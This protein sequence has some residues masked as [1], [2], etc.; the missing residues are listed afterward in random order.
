M[1]IER[2]E[3]GSRFDIATRAAWAISY[4]RPILMDFL[5]TVSL[6]DTNILKD[7]LLTML[8]CL[9]NVAASAASAGAAAVRTTT[10]PLPSC[11]RDARASIE[12][13]STTGAGAGAGASAGRH[14]APAGAAAAGA[15][16]ARMN[17]DRNAIAAVAWPRPG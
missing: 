8:G 16:A 9:E 7:Y 3:K 14:A 5:S 4:N 11:Q 13:T 6:G 1:R 17:V 10:S 15:I 12:Q 2:A